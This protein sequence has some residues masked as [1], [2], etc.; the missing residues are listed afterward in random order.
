MR[1][2]IVKSGDTYGRLTVVKET[3]TK[4]YIRFV[5]CKCNCGNRVEVRLFQM[6]AGNVKSC[7]CLQRERSSESKTIHGHSRAKNVTSEYR[8]WRHMHERCS[9][10]KDKS[11]SNYG[12]RGITV[13]KRWS[14]FTNFYKDMGKRPEGTSIDRIDN[15]KGYFPKNCR[16]ATKEQQSNNKRTNRWITIDGKTMTLTQW[17]KHLNIPIATMYRRVQDAADHVA[18]LGYD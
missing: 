4:K 3:E 15:N 17:S 14:S 18:N 16:W 12:G 9:S 8:T 11:F 6:R 7:G 13:C 10:K 1:S 2:V 5:L